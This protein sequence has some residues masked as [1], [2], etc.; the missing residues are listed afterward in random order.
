M[1]A[2]L[3]LSW[4]V[5]GLKMNGIA[6]S[7]ELWGCEDL[8]LIEQPSIPFAGNSFTANNDNLW[9]SSARWQL[10]S[11]SI[12]QCFGY[13]VSNK[14]NSNQRSNLKWKRIHNNV[15]NDE[16]N[17]G[18]GNDKWQQNNNRE[19]PEVVDKS[20]VNQWKWH[21]ASKIVLKPFSSYECQMALIDFTLIQSNARR[22]YSSLGNPLRVKGSTTWKAKNYRPLS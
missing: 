10:K 13:L 16:K 2:N 17:D 9:Y 14:L 5:S 22:F 21:N 11:F 1:P 8:A 15:D 4:S 19:S 12:Q 6:L 18:D 20:S 3:E 7:D